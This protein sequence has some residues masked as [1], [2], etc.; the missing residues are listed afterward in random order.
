MD[1]RKIGN[2]YSLLLVA[3]HTLTA[4]N[5]Y[6]KQRPGWNSRQ[7]LSRD[8]AVSIPFF[9]LFIFFFS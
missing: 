3:R 6:I 7:K 4:T 1:K 5:K 9:I 2:S 8:G